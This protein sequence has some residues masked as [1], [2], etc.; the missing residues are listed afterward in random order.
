MK[1]LSWMLPASLLGLSA[2]AVWPTSGATPQQLLASVA[3]FA[4]PTHD[5]RF[6]TLKSQLDAAGLPYTVEEFPGRR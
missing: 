3:A 2:C 5:A 1:F 6:E 4:H